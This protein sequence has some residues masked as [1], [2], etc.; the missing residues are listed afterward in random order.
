MSFETNVYKL[1][2]T[3]ESQIYR[4][5]STQPL[6]QQLPIA[7]PQVIP[8]PSHVQFQ[9]PNC[10]QVSTLQANFEKNF[11][12]SKGCEPFPKDNN[13]KC[14]KCN[15]TIDISDIRNSL[16]GQVNKKIV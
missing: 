16:E 8:N 7:P 10:N 15:N 13:F 11:P 1:Y 6:I 14:S 3:P 4:S 12:L 9:C 5:I 2:E